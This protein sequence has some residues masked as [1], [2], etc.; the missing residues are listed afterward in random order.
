MAHFIFQSPN[1]EDRSHIVNGQVAHTFYI[2][3][4]P[5]YKDRS[6]FVNGKMA[7]TFYISVTKLHGYTHT[8]EPLHDIT[9]ILHMQNMHMRRSASR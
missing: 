3:Q 1:C 5:N 8:F 7:H 9:N 2:S 6:H 4:L